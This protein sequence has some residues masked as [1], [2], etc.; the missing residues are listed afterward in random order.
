MIDKC[1][2][3]YVSPSSRFFKSVCKSHKRQRLLCWDYFTILCHSEFSHPSE[4]MQL[5]CSISGLLVPW[6]SIYILFIFALLALPLW[7]GVLQD[8]PKKF[9]F[10]FHRNPTL[11]PLIFHGD[12]FQFLLWCKR[13]TNKHMYCSVRSCNTTK[14]HDACYR[15][16]NTCMRKRCYWK[17]HLLFYSMHFI[18]EVLYRVWAL[19]GPLQGLIRPQWHTSGRRPNFFFN[20]LIF[21]HS[22]FSSR[23][24]ALCKS[25]NDK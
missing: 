17:K 5:F 13:I 3:F 25:S 21:F 12:G 24:S 22:K 7:H 8:Q 9:S 18:L 14:L 19:Y 10:S 11:L 1:S 16:S 20:I 6:Y 4:L 2:L 15:L 23:F